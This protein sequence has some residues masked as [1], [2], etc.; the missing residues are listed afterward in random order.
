MQQQHTCEFRAGLWRSGSRGIYSNTFIIIHRRLF[1]LLGPHCGPYAGRQNYYFVGGYDGETKK[2]T[3]QREIVLDQRIVVAELKF[4]KRNHVQN[5]QI[6]TLN[7]Y[8]RS[9]LIASLETLTSF[10]PDFLHTLK[11][12][13]SYS[14]IAVFSD[15]F[16]I[17]TSASPS[18]SMLWPLTVLLTSTG[19]GGPRKCLRPRTKYQPMLM[20]AKPAKTT[21]A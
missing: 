8:K 9:I 10:S 13:C 21:E 14:L 19:T 12:Y 15:S 17:P 5:Q 16:T 18:T 7:P 20:V 4:T 1:Y 2:N 6:H 3:H 11:V